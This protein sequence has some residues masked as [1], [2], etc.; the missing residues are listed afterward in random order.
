MSGGTE[1]S[2]AS[3]VL[4]PVGDRA[5][6]EGQ[7]L[8]IIVSAT[9]ADDGSLAFSASNLPAGAS[10]D[11]ATRT[12]TWTPGFDRAGDY[13]DVVFRASDGVAS[14]SENIK[15]TVYDAPAQGPGDPDTA[16][17][18]TTIDFGPKK[19]DKPRASFRFSSS[20]PGSSFECRLDEQPFRTCSS[21]KR[22]KRLKEGKHAFYVRATD[23]AGNVDPTPAK[24]RFQVF[25]P[26]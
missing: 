26:A 10:F 4:A 16:P 5:I 24:K 23:S 22:L 15:I 8:Q 25:A 17:P 3:P 9:D 20:E 13:P 19:V 18:Q 7:K 12:F 2:N 6:A 14:D 11:S 1:P 21:P